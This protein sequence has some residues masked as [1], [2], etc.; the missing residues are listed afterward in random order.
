VT[1]SSGTSAPSRAGHTAARERDL[2]EGGGGARLSGREKP[3]S[4]APRRP[5]RA[6]GI[7]LLGPMQGSGYKRAPCLVRRA[8]GQTIQLTS[9]LYEVLD[10]IDGQRGH[11]E[12][13]S[14]VSRRVSRLA[15]ADDIEY[16][17]EDKLRPLGVLR[18]ADG[19]D[20]AVKKMDPLL[21][22]RLRKVVTNPKV[23]RR[24]T[25]PFAVFFRPVIAIPLLIA[26]ALTCSWVLFEKGLASAAH[27]AFYE[28]GMLL[29]VIA[30]T[31]LS[32]G[33][34]EVGHAAAATYGGATPGA[35]GMG[36]YLV[37]PAFYTDV[38]DSYRL[39][40][41]GRLRVDLG[42][43][44][45]N[46]IFAVV[47]L[48]I[49]TLTGSDALLLLIPAQ[50][51]HMLHQLLPFVRFDG[52]HI[53]ADITGVPDLFAHIKPTLLQ[54][55]PSRWG[56][57]AS[58]PLHPWARVVV[59]LW[60]LAVVPVLAIALVTMAKVLPRLAATALDSIATRMDVLQENWTN[61]DPSAIAV[62]ILSLAAVALP[63][64][65]IT[66]LLVRVARRTWLRVW[67]ASEDRPAKR[68]FV[69][70]GA[71]VVVALL[72][73]TWWPNGQY[74]PIQPDEQG[75]LFDVGRPIRLVPLERTLEFEMPLT[76][77][78]T[79]PLAGSSAAPTLRPQL[80]MLRSPNGDPVTEAGPKRVVPLPG[81]E[82]GSA[83]P[84]DGWISTQPPAPPADR[85][86]PFPFNPPAPPGA[87]DNQALAVNTEDGSTVHDVAFAIIWVTDG[88]VDEI[89]EAWALANC[90]DCRTVAVAFQG[91]FT[92]GDTD[93]VIPQNRAVAVN[94]ECDRCETEAVAVQLVATL[95]RM[96][97]DEAMAELSLVWDELE[98]LEGEIEDLSA[99]EIQ[100]ELARIETKIIDILIR[101]GALVLPEDGATG[102]TDTDTGSDMTEDS[103]GDGTDTDGTTDGTTTPEE[104]STTEGEVP[105]EST[106]PSPAPSE[107]PSPAPSDSSS[108]APS[109]SSSPSPTAGG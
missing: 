88:S 67:R 83:I 109:D 56:K 58:R 54:L 57:T 86:W 108:P 99:D 38:T 16:L 59:T 63:V 61:S 17:I 89:N 72:A 49:W 98:R 73:W 21:G 79:T 36:L 10:A 28:P 94:Y 69:V 62:G 18:G 55:L 11:S 60:V 84:D 107:E 14:L 51:L 32:T 65:G 102:G 12:I 92:V 35:M 82:T 76:R 13:A 3:A 50:L 70:A 23:T 2:D 37:W 64:L 34:H 45:F 53:L 40:R 4:A 85:G 42:G 41:R 19:S 25:A 52:Y 33:F 87:G 9:L 68:M 97:S 5:A 93:V 104:T 6:E 7:E 91:I 106:E 81:S 95:T 22:L 66:Y 48:G 47:M 78:M 105:S 43:L 24:I 100:A 80:V 77:P 103:I 46:A 74:R 30:L 26:F 27:D 1:P 31:T 44:Y 39:D 29:L 20:P 8:D 90:S 101:D 15:T 96:P 71:V 75:T